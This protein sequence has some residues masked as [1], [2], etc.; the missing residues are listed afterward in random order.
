MTLAPGLR[1]ARSRIHGKGCFAAAR[2]TRRRKIAEYTGE[3]ITNAEAARRAA[4][5]RIWG[6]CGLDHGWSID[7]SR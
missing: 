5:R 2:F 3:R 1:V 4:R 7:G 6:L